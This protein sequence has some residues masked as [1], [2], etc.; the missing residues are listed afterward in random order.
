MTRRS[1]SAVAATAERRI[2]WPHVSPSLY[3]TPEPTLFLLT[4]PPPS[5]PRPTSSTTSA[6]DDVVGCNHGGGLDPQID[7][8]LVDHN[9]TATNDDRDVVIFEAEEDPVGEFSFVQ[10]ASVNCEELGVEGFSNGQFGSGVDA[11]SINGSLKSVVS[12]ANNDCDDF[13]DP[14]ETMSS[15]ASVI[16]ADDGSAIDYSLKTPSTPTAEY[17]DAYEELN[18]EGGSLYELRN[19]EAELR[20]IRLN[21]LMEIEKRKQVEETLDNMRRQWQGFAEKLS[22][23]GLTV[24]AIESATFEDENLAPGF[25]EELC[26][27]IHVARLVSDSV[28][29]GLAKAEAEME[30]EPVIEAKNFEIARLCDRLRYYEAVNHEMSQRNQETIELARHRRQRRKRRQRWVWGSVGAAI[31]LGS[32]AL[33]WSFLPSHSSSPSHSP[34]GDESSE[35]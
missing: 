20:D 4:P 18:S 17:F 10:S 29:R 12:G 21:L 14:N 35:Q 24:P 8:K 19:M 32:A 31:A 6:A 22:L 34:V 13:F 2:Q 9:Q 3:A 11:A 15:A 25:A 7:Q 5:R 26:Q 16:G 23:V 30:I 28:G 1:S 27:Q 33:V